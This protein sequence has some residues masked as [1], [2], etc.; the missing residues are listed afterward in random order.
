MTKVYIH[1]ITS[2]TDFRRGMI[3]DPQPRYIDIKDRKTIDM[4]TQSMENNQWEYW[5]KSCHNS[6]NFSIMRN[7]MAYLIDYCP[8][9]NH[10]FTL[11]QPNRKIYIESDN[12]AIRDKIMIRVINYFANECTAEHTS[13]SFLREL[14]GQ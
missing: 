4:L 1:D 7:N 13:E 5:A 6:C 2:K 14:C 9:G 12:P 11:R 8:S 3:A 10:M